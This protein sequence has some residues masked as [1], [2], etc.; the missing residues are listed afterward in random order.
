[1]HVTY[2]QHGPGLPRHRLQHCVFTN[3]SIELW[4]S[5]ITPSDIYASMPNR[6]H[7]HGAATHGLS[8]L[9]HRLTNIH[10]CYDH[11]HRPRPAQ[12]HTLRLLTCGCERSYM[13]H[14]AA[15]FLVPCIHD[16]W[17]NC[18][19]CHPMHMPGRAGPSYA[20]VSGH[21][22]RIVIFMP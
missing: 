2:K 10:S 6:H 8:Q 7:G 4:R 11:D 16:S 19:R 18:F 14:A 22:H 3:R 9:S 21:V 13:L 20:T 15:S 12:W 5:R 1:M 17:V